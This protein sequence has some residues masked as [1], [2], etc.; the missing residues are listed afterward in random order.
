[1]LPALTGA[2]VGTPLGILLY[3]AVK[4]GSTM[5]YPP[6]WWLASVVI[7]TPLAVGALTIIP[8]RVAARAAVAPGLR[9]GTG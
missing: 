6:A 3:E 5:A 8:S 7:A 9:S 2:L 4:H 1:M